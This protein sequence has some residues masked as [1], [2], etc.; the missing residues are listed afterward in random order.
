MKR[1]LLAVVL[2]VALTG[3]VTAPAVA[4]VDS[5][6]NALQLVNVSC[7]DA[8]LSFDSIWVPSEHSVVGH[9]LDANFVGVAK[10]I[11]ATD[12]AGNAVAPISVNQG[13]G[14]ASITTWCFWPDPGSPTGYIGA[15]ILFNANLR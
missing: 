11:Y 4:A 1:S 8:G 6:P 15:D 7:P 9:N 13:R 14:L 5:N 12:S 10:S 3:L 2:C